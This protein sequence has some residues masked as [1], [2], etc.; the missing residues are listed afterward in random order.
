VRTATIESVLINQQQHGPIS[1][2]RVLQEAA[3]SRG[4][5]A[6]DSSNSKAVRDKLLDSSSMR[7][8][9]DKNR[10]GNNRRFCNPA[11]GAK[12]PL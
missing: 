7:K 3:G 1:P 6:A 9:H 5:L 12:V 11:V 10:C 8:L 2:A 4:T